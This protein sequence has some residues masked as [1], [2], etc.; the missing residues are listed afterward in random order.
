VADAVFVGPWLHDLGLCV[1]AMVWVA[2]EGQRKSVERRCCSSD[3]I[4]FVVVPVAATSR[5]NAH[6]HYNLLRITQLHVL[7]E[8]GSRWCGPWLMSFDKQRP[9][10]ASHE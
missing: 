1:Y 2:Y 8:M 7:V 4:G 9:P 3:D 5:Q 6:Q 10:P